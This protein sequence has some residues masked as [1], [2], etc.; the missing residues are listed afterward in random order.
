MFEKYSHK[1]SVTKII[2]L[3]IIVL[4][5]IGFTLLSNS[6]GKA[7]YDYVNGGQSEKVMNNLSA[8][9]YWSPAKTPAPRYPALLSVMVLL[10]RMFRDAL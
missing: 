6:Q 4:G 1:R 5:V 8:L 10:T 2:V 7:K 9:E 3:L